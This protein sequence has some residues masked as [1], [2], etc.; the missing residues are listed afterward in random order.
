MSVRR[1]K[2]VVIGLDCATHQFVFGSPEGALPNLTRLRE[3]GQWGLLESCVPAVTCPAWMCMATS[4]DPGQLGIYGFRNRADHSYD[5][6]AIPNSRAVTAPTVWNIASE[7]RRR[8][9]IVG[10]PL[11]YPPTPLNGCMVSG[12]LAPGTDANYTYPAELRDVIRD[13]VP[14]YV[15]DVQDF[16][17]DDKDALLERLYRVTRY[18]FSVVEHLMRTTHWDLTWFVEMGVDR[19]QH[20]FWRYSATDHR[21]YER[22]N[23]YEDAILRYYQYIDGYVE[24]LLSMVPD[25]AIVMVVSDHGARSLAGAFCVNDWLIGQGLLVLKHRP[26]GPSKLKREWIDWTRTKVWAEGGYFSRIFVNLKGREPSGTVDLAE[27]D[28]F[29]KELTARIEALPDH[30]GTPMGNR[31]FR[32]HDLYR[33]VR[34]VP[35]DLL[36]YLGDLSWRAAGTI[37][38]DSLY[39]FENDTGPDDA[40]HSQHGIFILSD[41]ADPARGELTG[42]RIYDIAPT[43]LERMGLPVHPGMIG[44]AIP[45]SRDFSPVRNSA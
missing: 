36:V 6:L 39:L 37:G 42:V 1:R 35:P 11:T 8:S 28:S 20:A 23:Q 34:G 12:F 4:Q 27:L 22:G 32:P 2:A 21:Y 29:L 14:K 26:D 19:I 41:P 24:S 9:V 15:V 16:R 33:E 31:V 5:A 44:H 25:D 43:L 7:H 30:Q 18:H 3:Q 10:V 17:T 45:A 13:E 38:H 40:N